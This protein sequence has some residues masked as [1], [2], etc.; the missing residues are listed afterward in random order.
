MSV[1]LGETSGP[2]IGTNVAYLVD[3]R[4]SS[5]IISGIAFIVLIL[6]VYFRDSGKLSLSEKSKLNSYLYESWPAVLYTLLIM[7]NA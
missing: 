2:L 5:S 4:C 6:F 3:I 7:S 1:V